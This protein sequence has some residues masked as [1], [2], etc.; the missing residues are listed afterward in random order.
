MAGSL[1][2]PSV[3]VGGGGKDRHL[4]IAELSQVSQMQ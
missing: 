1:I 4:A 2:Y 3:G